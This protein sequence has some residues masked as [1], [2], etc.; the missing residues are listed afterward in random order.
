MVQVQ[1]GEPRMKT[2]YRK[3]SG[4]FRFGYVST[5]YRFLKP[6]LN[7]RFTPLVAKPAAKKLFNNETN[8]TT[9]ETKNERTMSGVRGLLC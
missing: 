3:G 2:R 8:C 1:E 5:F 4:F 7:Q 9:N 6:T